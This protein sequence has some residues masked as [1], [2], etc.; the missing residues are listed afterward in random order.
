[1]KK[2][3]T[4]RVDPTSADFRL[5]D[6]PFYH[7]NLAIRAY[8][9][10]MKRLLRPFQLDVARWRILLIVNE[11]QPISVSEVATSVIMEPSTVTRAMQRLQRDGLIVVSTRSTD[12]RFSE[13]ALTDLGGQMAKKVLEAAARIFADGFGGVSDAELGA[14][15]STLTKVHNR[16]RNPITS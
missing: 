13:A 11:H 9:T 14:L 16:L 1:M 15:I 10:E 4:K 12:Q 6:W 5:A 2:M 3:K 8:D 7:M